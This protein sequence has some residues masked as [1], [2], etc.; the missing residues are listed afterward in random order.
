METEF[1]CNKVSS[2]ESIYVLQIDSALF[3]FKTLQQHL[4]KGTWFALVGE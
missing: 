3:D 1:H 2:V 4:L